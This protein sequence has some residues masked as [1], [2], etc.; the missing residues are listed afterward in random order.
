VTATVV[1]SSHHAVASHAALAVAAGGLVLAHAWVASRRPVASLILAV[2]CA[3]LVSKRAARGLLLVAV[4]V[5]PTVNPAVIGFNAAGGGPTSGRVYAVQAIL[6][7][8]VLGGFAVALGNGMHEAVAGVVALVGLLVLLQT[9][10]R[11]SAGVAWLYR[12]LQLFLVAF[13]VR[14][15]YRRRDL[16][17]LLTGLAWG[18][19]IG[20]ALASVH[21]LVPRIDPFVL[22]RPS[23]LPFVSYIASFTRATGAFTYPNNLGTFAAYTTLLG[24]AALLL[25]RPALSHRLAALLMVSGGSALL[26]SGSRAAALGLLAG[27]LYLA[28]KAHPHRRTALILLQAVGGL[29][30]VMLVLNSPTAR[31]VAAQRLDTAAGES[32]DLRV[33]SWQEALEQFASSPVIGTGATESRTDNFW[34]LYL[35][36]GGIMG[37]V[38]FVLLARL[39]LRHGRR[40]KRYP[41][42]WVALLLAL[43]TSGLLQDSLGQTLTTWFVGVLIGI[44]ALQPRE[45][46]SVGF[47]PTHP[48][49][50]GGALSPE[51]R[52]P[53]PAPM[54]SP[55]E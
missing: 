19:A 35:A 53:A 27:L 47:E 13:A 31:E 43:C 55:R 30:V 48:P 22:S 16:R 17:G 41:E 8:V 20:C 49:P 54:V 9:V 45:A 7:L 38:I 40:P 3:C 24:A 28:V 26:L 34:L 12:P 2:V 46:P 52:G 32:L 18:S 37:A 4:V 39:T 33:S 50:E 29:L 42:L 14:A 11:P 1:G 21:A 51:L 36:Q 44:A 6:L 25:G 10:G 15:L 23:D 5:G